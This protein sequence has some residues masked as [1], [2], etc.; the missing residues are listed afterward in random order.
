MQENIIDTGKTNSIPAGLYQDG[1]LDLFLGV[2]AVF[3]GV[4]LLVGL[5]YLGGITPAI[6]LPVWQSIRQ[7]VILPRT[8]NLKHPK[9]KGNYFILCLLAGF[10]ALL[11]AILFNQV[12]HG[13]LIT[14]MKEYSLILIGI[15]LAV[16]T[17]SIGAVF[18]TRRLFIYSGLLLALIGAGYKLKYDLSW[19]SILFGVLVVCSGSLILVR[20][21]QENPVQPQRK[22]I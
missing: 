22:Y 12:N 16:L 5:P 21:I 18:Q 15:C 10:I 17:G 11:I 14:W 3:F 19:I 2:V 9:M 1:L 7:K 6:L 8:G 13:W 20:F 4:G